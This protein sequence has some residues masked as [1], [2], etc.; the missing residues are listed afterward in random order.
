ML[1]PQPQFSL[2]TPQNVT[3]HGSSRP[4]ARRRAAIGL[5]P[6]IV[7]YSSHSA[8]SRTEP[9]P[10]LPAIYGSHRDSGVDNC[11]HKSRNSCVPT[12]L[13]SV[14]PPQWTLTML[15]R[16]ARGPMPSVQW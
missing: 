13:F 7:R 14:T 9:L 12:W 16:R 8:I 6:D 11:S 3:G 10:S 1:P 4:L 2:P 5:S 15:G